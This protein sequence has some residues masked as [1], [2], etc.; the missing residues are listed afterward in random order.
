[1]KSRWLFNINH[2]KD[3]IPIRRG[4]IELR[5]ALKPLL[6]RNQ[7]RKP[8]ISRRKPRSSRESRYPGS[9]RQEIPWISTIPS[10]PLNPRTPKKRN[11]P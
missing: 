7:E 2:R 5:N 11:R 9:S 1:M 3:A 4:V 8:S 6:K 10:Q